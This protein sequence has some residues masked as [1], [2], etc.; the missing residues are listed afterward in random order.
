MQRK[1]GLCVL[2]VIVALTAFMSP[3]LARAQDG[4]TSYPLNLRSG[5]GA[6]YDV[7]TI[8]PAGTWMIMEARNGDTSWLL[9]HTEDGAYRGWVA[10]LYLTY[11]PGF[12]AVRLPVSDEIMPYQAPPAADVSS[13]PAGAP[14]AAAVPVSAEAGPPPSHP[15]ADTL[16]ALPLVPTISAHARAIFEQGQAMGN[17]ANVFAK[18]GECN[19]LSHAFMSPF[20]VGMYDLGPY[21]GLQATID[22]FTRESFGDE[23]AASRAGYTCAAV[24]D[25]TWTDPKVCPTN[26]TP[27]ECELDRIRPSVVLVNLGMHDV[28]SL[29]TQQYEQNMRAIIEISMGRGVIPVL[30]TFPVY[31]MGDDLTVARYEFDMIVVNLAREYDI[32]LINFWRAAEGLPHRGVGDDHVHLTHNADQSALFNGEENQYGFTMLNLLTLQTLDALRRDVL[33]N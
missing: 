16:A 23:S 31:P 18:V 8:L 11:Q 20:S 25:L 14:A 13:A 24:T 26:L 28:H 10:S 7:I 27:L 4:Q 6:T 29:T 21:G 19:T 5:P 9:G 1:L 12:S 2:I 33:A 22:F 15:I 30:A 17:H 32:P 3:N